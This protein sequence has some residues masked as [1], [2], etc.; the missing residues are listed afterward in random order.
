[1]WYHKINPCDIDRFPALAPLGD[2]L[3]TLTPKCPC[4]ATIRT[5]LLTVAGFAA[6]AFFF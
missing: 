2:W 6:G 4:C 1:M 3:A 5:F